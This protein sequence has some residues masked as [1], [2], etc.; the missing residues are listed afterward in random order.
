[1][2]FIFLPSKKHTP[3]NWQKAGLLRQS[4]L[5]RSWLDRRYRVFSD[6]SFDLGL[7]YPH[8]SLAEPKK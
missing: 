6:E 1:L 4:W 3:I 7:W 2:K 5:C 8:R